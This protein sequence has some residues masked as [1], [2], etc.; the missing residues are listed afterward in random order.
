MEIE[1][2]PLNN[3]IG[4]NPKD[5]ERFLSWVVRS[6]ET[7]CWLW[8]GYRDVGGYGKFTVVNGK[9]GGNHV[10]AHRFSYQV[11]IGPIPVGH[12][13]HHKCNNRACVNPNHLE[14]LSVPDHVA[15]TVGHASNQTHCIRG[16]EFSEEN[17]R[18]YNGFRT[19]R[20]CVNLRQI[21]KYNPDYKIVGPSS[22]LYCTNDH[23]L[24]GPTADI[25]LIEMVDGRFRRRCRTCRHE[26]SERYKVDNTEA[27]LTAKTLR[28]ADRIAAR[29]LQHRQQIISLRQTAHLL[30]ASTLVSLLRR[31][32]NDCD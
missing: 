31:L 3:V 6:S 13:V 10:P 8:K 26:A 20:A 7:E 30:P 23:P 18:I 27:I 21:W 12:Q 29:K 14:A 22:P 2:H 32:L 4:V 9:K 11:S 25:D 5:I 15:K 24:F 17:T 1:I 19:C 28:R 16:H